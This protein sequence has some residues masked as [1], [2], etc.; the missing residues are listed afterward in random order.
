[1]N[2]PSYSQT[3]SSKGSAT[4]VQKEDKS[5][6]GAWSK[7]LKKNIDFGIAAYN[8]APIGKYKVI[9]QFTILENGQLGEFVPLTRYGY[10]MEEEL[11]RVLKKSPKWNP[12]YQD[13]RFVKARRKQSVTFIVAE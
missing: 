6:N 3:D 7:F 8:N 4:N 10:G 5:E 11:I 12:P 9:V 13:G 2:L 1:M